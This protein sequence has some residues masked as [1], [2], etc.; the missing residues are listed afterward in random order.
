VRVLF[1]TQVGSGH[2]RPLAPFADALRRTN[3]EVAFAS[4]PISC[5]SIAA[6]GFRGFPI[7]GDDWLAAS[8][9]EAPAQPAQADAVLFDRFI[10]RAA[11]DLPAHV[12]QP[13]AVLVAPPPAGCTRRGPSGVTATGM[14]RRCLPSP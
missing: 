11:R 6:H 3:H 9:Q 7:G 14:Q 5:S 13:I 2:W 1:T 10:P 4:T 8:R 12:Q